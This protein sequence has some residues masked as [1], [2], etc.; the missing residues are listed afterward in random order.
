MTNNNVNTDLITYMSKYAITSD[1]TTSLKNTNNIDFNSYKSQLYPSLS[2][3]DLND[4]KDY[5]YSDGQFEIAT[6]NLNKQNT[7]TKNVFSSVCTVFALNGNSFGTGFLFKMLGDNNVYILTCYHTIKS[8][9]N[10]DIL[11]VSLNNTEND[12]NTIA[13]FDIIGYNVFIDVAIAKFNPD[14]EYNIINGVENLNGFDTITLSGDKITINNRDILY[15]IGNL[16]SDN[17]NSILEG[18]VIDNNYSGSFV[19]NFIVSNPDSIL[20][21]TNTTNGFSGSPVFHNTSNKL[22]GMYNAAYIMDSGGTSAHVIQSSYLYTVAVNIIT[23]W[24]YFSKVYANN[25]VYLSYV[26]KLSTPMS[27]LGTI[28]SYYN[29]I[30]SNK[31]YKSLCNFGY[32]GGLVIENFIYGFDIVKKTFVTDPQS[33]GMFNVINLETPLLNTQIYKRYIESSRSPIVIKSMTYYNSLTNEFDKITFGKY[34]NQQTYSIFSFGFRSISQTRL[35]KDQFPGKT[36]ASSVYSTF[37]ELKINYFYFNGSV[38]INEDCVIGGSDDSWHTLTTDNYGI[39][40]F[41]SKFSYPY[42]LYPYMS[43]YYESKNIG[44]NGEF[45]GANGEF[46]GGNGEFF[47]GNGEF[48]GGNEGEFVKSNGKVK[49]NS[50]FIGSNKGAFVKKS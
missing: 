28:M 21:N 48:F 38:W 17:D 43:P 12:I 34:G 14:S 18:T 23:N 22:V 50:T 24:N 46:F 45:F 32:N 41:Q 2:F 33:I 39:S 7:E 26:V 13:E 42:V 49:R 9:S 25:K 16:G 36:F 29:P 6:F 30:I 20:I 1:L 5:F 3:I 19:N 47:G 31:K 37:S 8:N 40:Y 35:N 10:F 11:K 44:G 27:W 4:F 15:Y